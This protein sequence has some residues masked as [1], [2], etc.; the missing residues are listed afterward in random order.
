MYKRCRHNIATSVF[1]HRC[2]IEK[3]GE[4]EPF[5]DWCKRVA[6]IKR[7]HLK[8]LEIKEAPIKIIDKIEKFKDPAPIKNKVS[9]W[10]RILS[11][12][13]SCKITSKI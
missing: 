3:Y 4:L 8:D 6:R 10:K 7:P 5:D 11:W 2:H 1:C 9:W 13:K 12:L